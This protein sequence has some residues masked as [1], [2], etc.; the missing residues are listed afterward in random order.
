MLAHTRSAPNFRLA[1]LLAAGV[2]L[3]QTAARAQVP[4]PAPPRDVLVRFSARDGTPLE[5]KLSL[6]AGSADRVP[7]VLYLH[8]A[9]PRTYDHA[10]RYR[11]ADGEVRTLNYFDLYA[12]ELAAQGVAFFRISKRGC[13]ADSTGRPTIDRDIF[14]KA[15][16]TVLL[17]DYHRALEVLRAR[18]EVDPSRVVLMGSSEGT[19]LAPQLA[20]R[21][22]VG[23]AGLVLMSHAPDNQRNTVE[24][25][26]TVGPWRNVQ[27]L[28]APAARDVLTRAGY[29]SVVARQPSLAA[30]LPFAVVDRD[31]NQV[32]TPA[33]LATLV[34]PRL[35]A[36]VKAVDD[37]NDDFLWQSLLNLSS[38]YLLDGWNAEPTSAFLLP[39]TIPIGIFHGELDGTTRVEGVRETEDAF[40]RAG[41][42]NLTVRIYP[43]MDHN[44][45]WTPTLALSGGP[46]PYRDAF[47]FAA[48]LVQLRNR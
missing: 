39:L 10:V 22:A 41:K 28:F 45:G 8:G 23:I 18:P 44:L 43:G 7:V 38:A 46:A 34:R 47:R 42:T 32:I 33:E 9:G 30:Q 4:Q 21:A 19:R 14:S 24:W 12:S 1:V 2:L 40:R 17:D 37:R 35:D 26:N 6:P 11:D 48:A 5:G 36:I 3:P 15:T 13:S 25:Q 31:S 20:A 27:R 29:D 16:P